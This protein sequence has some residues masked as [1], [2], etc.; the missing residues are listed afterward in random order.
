MKRGGLGITV[1]EG[2]LIIKDMSMIYLQFLKLN[3][4]LSHFTITSI[5]NTGIQS[6]PW[7][8][9]KNR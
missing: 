4:M 1:M 3:I 8:L 6:S 5:G 9:K 7:K 2:C